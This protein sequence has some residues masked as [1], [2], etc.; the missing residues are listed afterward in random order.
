MGHVGKGA[1]V[2]AER[3]YCVSFRRYNHTKG[4]DEQR[5]R[6]LIRMIYKLALAGV[7]VN[8]RD[9][10]GQTPLILA[11]ANLDQGLM[12]HILRIGQS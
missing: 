12:T 1:D 11:S 5:A 9:A 7:D 10:W 2:F 6:L 8:A 4:E 3:P